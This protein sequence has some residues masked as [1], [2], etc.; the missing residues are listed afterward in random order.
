MKG[1]VMLLKSITVAILT[2]CMIP[3]NAFAANK[4]IKD[5]VKEEK[6]I[7]YDQAVQLAVDNNSNL[8][9]LADTVDLM[10]DN[11][12]LMHSAAY[13]SSPN[14]G[15]DDFLI[16]S[17]SN[18]NSLVA[19]NNYD[20]GIKTSKLQSQILK[21]G[22]EV[23]VKSFFGNIK[24]QE[25]QL[26]L[27]QKNY[28]IAQKQLTEG[29]TKL[30]LG[31]MSQNDFTTLQNTVKE[32]EQ[33]ITLQQLAIEDNYIQLNR[34][35]G[36]DADT[37]YDIQYDVTFEPIDL[38]TDIDTYVN[39]KIQTDVSLE[40]ER[41]KAEDAKFGVNMFSDTGNGSS[42]NEKKNNE[43]TA[44]RSLMDAVETKKKDIRTAYVQLQQMESKQQNLEIALKNAETDYATAKVNYS[45]GNITQT[46]LKQAELA[47]L[48]AENDIQ[49]NML[50]YDMLRY[51]FDNTCLLGSSN[52]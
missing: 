30:K 48:K 35:L 8:R 37:V 21:I 40:I 13:P 49:Q 46:Q 17:S 45:V 47:I 52:S 36:L 50:S 22:A 26:Q 23:S 6:I 38:Q 7:T 31:V 24:D 41:V 15:G 33:N 14:T 29:Q 4:K 10:Q 18:L 32:M 42:Y 9:S 19:M 44:N 34:L 11:K 27:L 51:T 28:E 2:V 3:S 25:K 20:T 43:K 5:I 39:K 16:M 12:S 1:K